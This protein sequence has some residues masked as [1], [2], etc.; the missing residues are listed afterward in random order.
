MADGRW[1]MADGRWQMADGRWLLLSA[2]E[3]VRPGHRANDSERAISR[4]V[5]LA[6]NEEV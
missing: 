3:A 1:L 2:I 5:K 4:A 6:A